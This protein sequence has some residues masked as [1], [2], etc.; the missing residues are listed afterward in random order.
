MPV[1]S[2]CPE[3]VPTSLNIVR[4]A[5]GFTL[6]ELLVVI[7]IIALLISILLPSLNAA[8]QQAITIKCLSN[9]RTMGL[10]MQ[11]YVSDNKQTY[12]QPSNNS[13]I[14]VSNGST[15]ITITPVPGYTT[16]ST[17]ESLVQGQCI[18][19]NALDQYLN[20]NLKDSAT[21]KS[22]NYTAIKQDPVYASFNE[23][24]LEEDF[25]D[26][27]QIDFDN[28]YRSRTIKMSSYFG[29]PVTG[30]AV[31][32]PRWTR[33]SRIKNSSETVLLFDGIAQDTALKPLGASSTQT[34]FGG[35][36]N[37]VAIRHN[38]KKAA[39]V[40]FVDG[41]AATITQSIRRYTSGGAGTL[42]WYTWQPEYVGE[43]VQN[44]P[45]A[46]MVRNP[47]QTLTW[48]FWR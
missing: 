22:R 26:N 33:T 32:T 15:V 45:T 14:A 44:D 48:C 34:D 6:V 17:L 25:A 35:K 40:L 42:D 19:F 30:V 3:S 29:N 18:W 21:A 5:I 20:R 2:A 13:K 39:N 11:M 27:G 37:S 47:D 28:N 1:F 9:M 16:T 24:T 4:K 8:R 46:A 12:P 23:P 36:W 31:A 43:S 41:H 38:R 7:G 10:A